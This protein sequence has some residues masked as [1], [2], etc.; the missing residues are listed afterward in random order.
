MTSGSDIANMTLAIQVTMQILEE[1]PNASPYEVTNIAFH[2]CFDRMKELK[3][4]NEDLMAELAY[5]G[6]YPR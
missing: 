2:R 1:H 3:A 4:E 5:H 6:I